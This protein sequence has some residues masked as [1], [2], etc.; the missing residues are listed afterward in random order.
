MKTLEEVTS[1]LKSSTKVRAILVE[2]YDV[3]VEGSTATFYL[4]NV[5]YTD[6]TTSTYYLPRIVSGVSFTESLDLT[7]GQS[8]ISYGDIEINNTDHTL[9]TWLSHVWTNRSIKIF[10]GDITWSRSDFYPIFVGVISDITARSPDTLNL[11]LLNMMEK[12]NKP[13]S[14]AKFNNT[15]LGTESLLPVTFGECFNITPIA[16]NNIPNSLEYQ[17]H[18]GSIERIIE[19]RD[20]GAPVAFTPNLASGKFNLSNA[21]YG[22]VTCSVQGASAGGYSSTAVNV[23]RSILA[24]SGSSIPIDNTNFDLINTLNPYS[25]GFF[26]SGDSNLLET[27]DSIAYSIGCQLV[28]GVDNKLRLIKL[29]PNEVTGNTFIVTPEDIEENSL[30]ISEKWAIQSATKLAYCRNWTPQQSGLANGLPESSVDIFKNEWIYKYS[31]NSDSIA[32]NGTQEE[33]QQEDSLLISSASAEL[34]ASR[35]TNLRSIPRFVFS[36]V[37]YPHLLTVQLG[38]TIELVSPRYGLNNGKLGL[39]VSIDKNWINGMVTI[40]VLI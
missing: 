31:V 8:S 10:V 39:V 26:S 27:C 23:I 13:I 1:W 6:S 35:R 36:L 2:V 11:V 3:N 28:C 14:S 15:N 37:G 29:D 25:V 21:K 7:G 4:S 40:N 34:E 9:D 32:L 33:T 30:T 22:Q 20:N 18:N 17:V 19:V 38:D 16:T 24:Y 12:L 5:P